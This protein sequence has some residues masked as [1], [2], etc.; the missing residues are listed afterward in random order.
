[1]VWGVTA[2]LFFGGIVGAEVCWRSIGYRS[3][4][5]D[6]SALWKH[7][8]NRVVECGP[9]TI[10]LVGTSRIQS[11]FSTARIRQRLPNYASVQLGVFGGRGTVGVLRALAYDERFSGIVVVDLIEPTLLREFWDDEKH[12]IEYPLRMPERLEAVGGALVLDMLSMRN[13]NTG[14]FAVFESA[15]RNGRLPPIEYFTMRADRT[16]ELDFRHFKDTWVSSETKAEWLYSKQPRLE[17]GALD[18]ELREIDDFVR[19]IRSRGGEVV[20]VRMPSSGTRLAIEEDLYAKADF[21][22]R[23]SHDISGRWLHF[24]ELAGITGLKC[25]DESHLDFRDVQ[26]FTDTVVDELLL[27]RVLITH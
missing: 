17:K 26:L 9:R 7:W 3:S 23:F 1:M 13:P 8:W 15:V 11:G 14:L 25:P 21:W 4:A 27:R 19:R 16:V 22:D 10:V 5:A 20:F 12:R 24:T 18:D 2:S 6:S